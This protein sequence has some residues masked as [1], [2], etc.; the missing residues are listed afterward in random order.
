MKSLPV[1]CP[2]CMLP[3]LQLMN[4]DVRDPRL[5]LQSL[6]L[7]NLPLVFCWRCAVRQGELQYRVNASGQVELQEWRS[8]AMDPGFPYAGYPVAF[9]E[10]QVDLKEL[11]ARRDK[12]PRHQIGGQP[13][14]LAGD[15]YLSCS[16]C[17]KAM[18]FL[19]SVADSMP[20]G[21]SVAG[22]EWVQTVFWLCKGCAVVC[23]LQDLD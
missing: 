5:G 16:I 4:L 13:L 10:F 2:N 17:G 14:L 12:K 6:G 15:P 1:L 8:G 3:F 20:S 22:N 21:E 23:V 9:A 19:A 18:V 7:A 11:P